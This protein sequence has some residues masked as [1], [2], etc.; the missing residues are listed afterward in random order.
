MHATCI[1]LHCTAQ[2]LNRYQK[3]EFNAN[4]HK[5]LRVWNKTHL[6]CKSSQNFDRTNWNPPKLII[7]KFYQSF[8][9]WFWMNWVNWMKSCA[10]LLWLHS[11]GFIDF[12]SALESASHRI[13]LL[14]DELG[15]IGRRKAVNIFYLWM[16]ID[17]DTID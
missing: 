13:D 1:A 12:F 6:H 9:I 3:T 2:Q 17:Q 4:G 14:M 5:V 11:V 10:N 16:S 15:H 8:N 7:S